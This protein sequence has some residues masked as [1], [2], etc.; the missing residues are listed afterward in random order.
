MRGSKWTLWLAPFL[1]LGCETSDAEDDVDTLA[2]TESASTMETETAGQTDSGTSASTATATGGGETID[3]PD[4]GGEGDSMFDLFRC[5]YDPACKSDGASECA[6]TLL[7][8][9]TEAT[10]LL[11]FRPRTEPDRFLDD[12]LVVLLGDGTYLVQR[13]NADCNE[14]EP[15][16]LNN[17]EVSEQELCTLDPF[18]FDSCACPS[19]DCAPCTWEPEFGLTDCAPIDQR[20]CGEFSDILEHPDTSDG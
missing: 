8:S 15:D 6:A 12:T 4:T 20:T 18:A 5:G 14:E 7:M 17:A 19:E 16:C 1:L 2:G 13:R 10:G 3:P 9:S 11:M